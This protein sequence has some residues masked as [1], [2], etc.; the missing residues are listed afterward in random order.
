M[1]FSY[2]SDFI[3][4]SAKEKIAASELGVD[5]SIWSCCTDTHPAV[6]QYCCKEAVI[7]CKLGWMDG[8]M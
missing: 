7:K 4:W 1:I 2:S 3:D 6:R 8:W 5:L